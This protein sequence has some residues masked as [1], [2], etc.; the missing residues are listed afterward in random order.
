MGL[1]HASLLNVISE[2]ELVAVCDRSALLNQL[3]KKLFSPIKI[4]VVKDVERL[5]GLDLDVVYVTTPIPTHSSL[6]KSLY[7]D[8]IANN[9]F[10]EKTLASD[11]DQARELCEIARKVR[12]ITMV[13][14]MKRFNVAF[15]KAKELLTKRTIGDPTS[16]KAYAYSSDFLGLRKESKSSASR[17][18][19]L[20]DSGCHVIDMALWLLGDLFVQDVVSCVKN[21]AGSETSVSFTVSNSSD[22]RGQFD[23]SQIMPNYRMP[24]FGLTVECT[25]GRID[26]TDDRLLLVP[27]G[28]ELQKWYRHDLN[29]NVP[30]SIMDPEYFRENQ[31]FVNSLLKGIPC[32]PSFDTASK[33]DYLIGQVRSRIDQ[34]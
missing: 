3:Y 1:L 6:I 5:V 26:V 25:M 9:I 32:E 13:G 31:Y 24:E 4:A 23:V 10:V 21:Q 15:V 30:F 22:L 8:G 34:K 27:N 19:A 16:F 28:G 33:V 11:Y 7:A 18:G 14:Y 20:S 2:I 17:G 29:D 12:G